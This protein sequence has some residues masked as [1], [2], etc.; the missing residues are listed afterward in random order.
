MR[1]DHLEFQFLILLESIL[2]KVP[3]NQNPFLGFYLSPCP[4]PHIP[5]FEQGENL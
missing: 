5:H 3:Q 2:G 4:N 1:Q